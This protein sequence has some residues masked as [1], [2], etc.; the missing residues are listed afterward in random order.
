MTLTQYPRP[1]PIPGH[2]QHDEPAPLVAD[3]AWSRL[4]DWHLHAPAERLPLPLVPVAWLSAWVLHA[5]HVPGHVVTYVAGAAVAVTWLTWRWHEKNSPHP[6]LAAAEAALVTAAIGGWIAAAVTSGPLGWPAHLLTWVYVTG[7]IGGYAWLRR[8][9][10]VR[11]ARQRRDE[12]AAWTARKAEWH[13]IAHLIG[14]GDFH[15]QA[16]TPTRLGEELLL[17]SAPGSELATHVAANSRRYA[18]K[19]AHLAGLPYGRIDIRTTDYPGQLVIEVREKTAS[20]DGPVTHPALDPGSPYKDQ[21]PEPASIRDPVP[22]QVNPE[23]G[24]VITL[25]LWDREGGKAI[26]VYGMTGSGKTN[27][28]DGIRERVTAMDDAILIDLNGAGAGDE[29]AWAPLAACTAAGLQADDPE[30]QH[31][32][33]GAL[34]WARTL[35]GE[36]SQTAVHTGDSVFQPTRDDPAVVILADEIDE[37]GKIEGVSRL[38]EFLASKQRKAAVS[39]ILAGQRATA[40]W[41]GGAGVR[42]NLSTLVVGLLARDSESRHA[43]GAENEIPDIAEYSGGDSGFFQVWSTR[44]K[45][46]LARGRSFWMGSIGEQQ[47]LIISRRDP[48]LRPVLAGAGTAPAPAPA[49]PQEQA[50]S[51]LRERLAHVREQNEGHPLP[52][53]TGTLPVV[54]G[55]PPEAVA[56]LMRLLAR[57]PLSASEAGLAI[58]VSKPTAKR[59]MAALRDAGAVTM[60]GG[61]RGSRWR[62]SGPVPPAAASASPEVER[63]TTLAELAEAAH[64]GRVPGMTGEQRELLEQVWQI[65]HRPR[66]TVITG[67]GDSQ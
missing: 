44:A 46:V 35:I 29:L 23:T 48:A 31:K 47:R 40:A 21:F 41:T 27:L 28:L 2:P 5:A 9:E 67:G 39:L 8:H 15:L 38:L 55:V 7:A 32:I 61:G 60:T 10:A 16:V 25:P 36:R 43:V 33:T 37:L 66:L 20:V 22:I 45:R 1:C 3:S 17:T 4:R 34:Q 63:Y 64:D 30:L 26:G 57:G 53:G 59:Y 6:R 62:P 13:R 24:E 50:G 54:P 58:G 11:A 14:L 12:A 19:Y 65:G 18:E 56:V 51:V 49:A 42:I 52:A